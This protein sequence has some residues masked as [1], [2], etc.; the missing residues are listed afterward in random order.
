M[1]LSPYEISILKDRVSS[2]RD[3]LDKVRYTY[4]RAV[5]EFNDAEY[6][7]KR[8]LSNTIHSDETDPRSVQKTA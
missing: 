2:A 8:A 4:R 7:L 3:R 5:L 6:E 1:P